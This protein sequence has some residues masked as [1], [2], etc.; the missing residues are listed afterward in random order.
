MARGLPIDVSG[1]GVRIRARGKFLFSDE[2]VYIRGVT[3]GSFRPDRDGVP[4]PAREI[5]NNDFSFMVASG[6]N[7]LRVYTG[8]PGWLLDMAQQHGLLVMVGL[9]WEQHIAFL[10][11]RGRADSI[12]QRVREGVRACAGHPAVLCYAIGNEIPGSIVRWYGARRIER[13]LQRLYRAAKSEDPDTLV[14]YVNYPTTEYLRL[15]FLDFLCFNVYLET[16][17]KLEAYLAKLQNLARDRP[18]S[19]AEVGLDSRRHGE[20]DRP[21]SCSGKY[22]RRSSPVA[23]ACSCFRG[24]MNGTAAAL[25]STTGISA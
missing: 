24:R 20:A 18:W 13:F 10:D 11:E 1:V 25:M 8:P 23:R 15:P 3:Y 22:R 17:E 12:E 16:Q 4:F 6:I 19:W 9:P 2:K 5:V 7:A 21:Q 14:T